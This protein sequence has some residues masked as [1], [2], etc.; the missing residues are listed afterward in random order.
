MKINSPVY[1]Y[2]TGDVLNT[3]KVSESRVLRETFGPERKERKGNWERLYNKELLD[4][5]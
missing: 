1:I 3:L 4:Q 5:G 2:C